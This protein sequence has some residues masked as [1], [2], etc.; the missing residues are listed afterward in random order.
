MEDADPRR[1]TAIAPAATPNLTARRMSPERRYSTVIAAVK[2]S[3]AA[4]VSRVFPARRAGTMPNP[5]IDKIKGLGCGAND[6][7]EGDTSYGMRSL[8]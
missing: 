6:Y 4:V 1:V 5:E 2:A 3:P 8:G 7:I